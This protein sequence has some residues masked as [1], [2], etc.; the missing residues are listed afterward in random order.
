MRRP[1][2]QATL[3]TLAYAVATWIGLGVLSTPPSVGI[4]W[5][6]T[7][8]L[9]GALLVLRD[10]RP[11]PV[12]LGAWAGSTALQMGMGSQPVL[13]ALVSALGVVEALLI[14]WA[15]PRVRGDVRQLSGPA[16][17]VVL[18]VV[19]TIGAAVVATPGALVLAAFA[20]GSAAMDLWLTWV[21]GHAIGVMLF[22]PLWLAWSRP[23]VVWSQPRSTSRTAEAVGAFTV[24]VGGTAIVFFNGVGPV[25]APALLSLPHQVLPAAVWVAIRFG[26]RGA[27]LGMAMAA[28]VAVAGLGLGGGPMR[29]THE[30]PQDRVLVM[31]GFVVALTFGCMLLA[32][33][34]EQLRW[35]EFQ[36]RMLNI[37]LTDANAVLVHEVAERERSALSLRMLL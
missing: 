10:L 23:D 37:A 9:V 27:S 7:G 8:I 30:L 33:A 32:I 26:P 16:S 21:A 22:T 2:V 15:L 14:A 13:A 35:Q 5:P 31:Q 28:L 19:A 20:P 4:I 6:A 29:I 12:A 25:E 3:V 17:F 24:L 11:A 18:S 36:G 34:I 1:A